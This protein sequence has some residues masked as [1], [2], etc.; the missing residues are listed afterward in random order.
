MDV[1]DPT[2]TTAPLD[3]A[4]VYANLPWTYPVNREEE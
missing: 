1:E 3:L 4:E 2:T